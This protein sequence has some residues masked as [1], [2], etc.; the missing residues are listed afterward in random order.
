MITNLTFPCE[1]CGADMRYIE[2]DLGSYY[3]CD[4]CGDVEEVDVLEDLW[5]SSEE[6]SS[7]L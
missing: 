6:Q 7:Q 2:D 1:R 5:E 3:Y 4:G